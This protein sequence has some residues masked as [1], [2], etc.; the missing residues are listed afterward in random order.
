MEKYEEEL[1]Q[2]GRCDNM[3]TNYCKIFENDNKLYLDSNSVKSIDNSRE[4]IESK[5]TMKFK[6]GMQ[7]V[8]LI[9]YMK[10]YLLNF[11]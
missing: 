1:M 5:V 2:N 10:F 4:Q 7:N 8:Y 9:S 11:L 3:L 6:A